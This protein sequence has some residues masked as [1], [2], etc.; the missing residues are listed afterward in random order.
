MPVITRSMRR[1]AFRLSAAARLR[2][3]SPAPAASTIA[4]ATCAATSAARVRRRVMRGVA[5]PRDRR[6]SAVSA[7]RPKVAAISETITVAASAAAIAASS[8][9]PR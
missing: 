2:A 4:T 7:A 3:N 5:P 6:L 9:P 1:P 8:A